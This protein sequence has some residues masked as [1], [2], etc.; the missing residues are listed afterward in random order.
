MIF[1]P[2]LAILA[3]LI[4]S[5]HAS[6]V[7]YPRPSIYDKSAHF[8]LKVNGTYAYT[9][10][11]AGYDYVQ[12]S[13]DEGYDTEFRI[14]L[15]AGDS[16][17]SYSISPAKLPISAKTEGNELV[18]SLTK[19]HY[20]IVKINDEKEFV[21]LL[22]PSEV[23][24]PASSG[25]TIYNVLDYDADNTGKSLT[26]GIQAA[27]DAAAEKP[28]STV[29]VPAGLY[30]IG[31]LM[32]RN[33]T[34]LYIAGGAVLRFSGNPSDYT[35]LYNKAD[36]YD[37]TWWIQTEINSTNIKLYG[38]GTIDG[39]GYNTR[40]AKFMADLVVP[41]GTTNFTY[42]GVLVRDSSFWAVTPIQ[43]TDALLTNLKILDRQDVTQDDGIDV[44][45]ST[46]VTV[47]RSI[48]I[49]NDD[50]YSAKTWQYNVHTTVPYPYAP[51][52]LRDVLFEDCLAWTLCFSYKIGEGVW[53]VQDNVTFRDSVTYKAGVGIGIHHKF[54]SEIASNITFENI[55][56]ERLSGSPAGKATWM[57]IYV[58]DAGQGV[59]PLKDLTIKNIRARQ[60]GKGDAYL[61]GY[62]ESSIVSDVTISDVYIHDSKVPAT[63]FEEMKLF[64]VSHSEGIEIVNS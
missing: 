44:I 25:S 26:K 52:E 37:G 46:R 12:V 4:S 15:T 31:N 54:G 61:A 10:S 32:L 64:H 60:Q 43:V 47:R 6:F 24:V 55:D 29:Y 33:H 38:R 34:S 28:G 9:V 39:N 56:I 23:D 51:R 21:V 53:D 11:Y 13:M 20:L 27:M 16:I 59:G 18:F 1:Q 22:D 14:A 42:D 2:F 50:S 48:A 7:S 40:K 62:N 36:L 5:I 41:V 63:T 49:A 19:A 57:A 3:L 35:T 30:T 17:T 45:E 58:D 8:S